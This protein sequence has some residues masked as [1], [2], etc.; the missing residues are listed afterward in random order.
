MGS[1]PRGRPPMSCV[2]LGKSPHLTVPRSCVHHMETIIEHSFWACSEN[3]TRRLQT[4]PA[5][6]QL[7][8]NSGYHDSITRSWQTYCN[9]C[10]REGIFGFLFC[11]V[12]MLAMIFQNRDLEFGN[13]G[14]TQVFIYYYNMSPNI[15]RTSLH[16]PPPTTRR[17]GGYYSLYTA[18]EPE[19]QSSW[20]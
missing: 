15:T 12:F 19:I 6:T 2:T 3:P 4:V 11:F 1:M 14:K 10:Q 20:G 17:S 9:R 16:H 8:G 18:E 13:L 5:G 7:S